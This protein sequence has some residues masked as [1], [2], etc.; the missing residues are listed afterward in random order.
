MAY[1]FP[2]KKKAPKRPCR[3]SAHPGLLL[4]L[5]IYSLLP[6]KALQ[7]LTKALMVLET[8]DHPNK[9]RQEL[10]RWTGNK[11]RPFRATHFS[12]FNLVKGWVTQ[13]GEKLNTWHTFFLAWCPLRLDAALF[14]IF[15]VL[16]S[17]SD[18]K[19]SL[20]SREEPWCRQGSV[21]CHVAAVIIPTPMV[22]WVLTNGRLMLG[23]LTVPHPIYTWNT[24]TRSE[25]AQN[26]TRE[27]HSEYKKLKL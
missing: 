19:S 15:L 25:L 13:T 27:Y 16:L 6:V 22:W 21:A 17:K 18:K 2:S 5:Q 11:S 12:N 23:K 8:T 20:H 4:Q 7:W 3:E 26:S 10:T 24:E 14:F 1:S 9:T